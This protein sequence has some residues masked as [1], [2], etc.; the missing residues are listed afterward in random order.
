MDNGTDVYARKVSI[1][2]TTPKWNGFQGRFYV[3]PSDN[4]NDGDGSE[5]TIYQAGVS[6]DHKSGIFGAV[7]GGYIKGGA[8]NKELKADGSKK[9]AYQVYGHL[10]YGDRGFNPNKPWYVAAAYK[11]SRNVDSLSSTDFLALN[12]T[13][14]AN[15]DK[16]YIQRSQDADLV[17]TYMLNQ[18]VKLKSTVAFGWDY[19]SIDPSTQA[20]EKMWGNGK[21]IQGI[22]GADY[23]FSKRTIGNAQ[24]GTFHA[25]DS[26]HRYRTNVLSVGMIY[27]F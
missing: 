24:V 8:S 27:R 2:Y 10:G 12:T 22:L 13:A 23:A 14:A 21:Y 4:N 11:Y 26:A 7:S 6:Y 25:G 20:I 15:G 3:S 17:L 18:H 19:H 16:T 1:Q 5:A 9:D